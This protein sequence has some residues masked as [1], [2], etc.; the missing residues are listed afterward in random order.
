VV[1]GFAHVGASGDASLVPP[2]AVLV[3]AFAVFFA[4]GL[5]LVHALRR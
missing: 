2:G 1:T 4:G 5:G 3:S